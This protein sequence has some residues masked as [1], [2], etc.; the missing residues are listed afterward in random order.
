MIGAETGF[1]FLAVDHRIG[2]IGD[3]A[4]GFPD[5]GV[6]EDGGIDAFDIVALLGHGLPP[7]VFEIAFEFDAVGTVVPATAET[8]VDFGR[9]KHKATPF[10]Q[11]NDLFHSVN[12]L[13]HGFL[14]PD[15]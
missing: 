8:A 10:A 7:E 13:R 15:S 11:G 12:C 4:G 5:F 1:A 9:L 6:H 14:H 3:M 2:E